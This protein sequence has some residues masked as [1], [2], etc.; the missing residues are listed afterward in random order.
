VPQKLS[1]ACPIQGLL[2]V[3]SG[4]IRAGLLFL[5]KI[6]RPLGLNFGQK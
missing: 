3:I 6:L 4:K 5:A 2:G 1:K